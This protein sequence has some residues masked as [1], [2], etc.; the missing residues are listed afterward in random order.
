MLRIRRNF[1]VP[2]ASI[3]LES[4]LALSPLH[5]IVA[6]RL[7]GRFQYHLSLLPKEPPTDRGYLC[8]VLDGA[9]SMPSAGLRAEP[10]QVVLAQSR[11]E[12]Y[13]AE[14][15]LTYSVPSS[16]LVL[17]VDPKC[18]A[19]FATLEVREL[20]ALLP[21]ANDLFEAMRSPD[22]SEASFVARHRALL[23][24][25]VAEGLL[26]VGA[27]VALDHRASSAEARIAQALSAAFSLQAS[28]PTLVDMETEVGL[29]QRTLRR[30]IRELANRYD[31]TFQSWRSLREAWSRSVAMILLTAPDATPG[32]VARW[33]GYSDVASLCH[34]LQRNGL[35][36]PGELQ[37]LA[38]GIS[39]G[40]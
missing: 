6:A 16:M 10:G 35:P 17:R 31:F 13:E 21:R 9:L 4:H 5:R 36:T 22:L 25:L 20:P 2:G 23:E 28:L 38:A 12:L 32:E 24:A 1:E 8:I 30:A 29:S 39:R 37:R 15:N 34:T 33:L 40:G 26:A 11:R 3:A 14:P 19:S 18:C 27:E 7:A